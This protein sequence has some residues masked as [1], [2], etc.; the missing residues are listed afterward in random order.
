[1][2]VCESQHQLPWTQPLQN[3]LSDSSRKVSFKN[4]L[5]PVLKTDLPITMAVSDY[6]SC[7]KNVD[8]GVPRPPF[9]S[10][11]YSLDLLNILAAVVDRTVY[12]LT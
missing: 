6:V 1:M 9:S 10:N 5:S 4:M 2:S 7:L 12:R 3:Y 8:E 11:M